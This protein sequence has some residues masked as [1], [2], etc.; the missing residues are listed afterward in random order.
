MSK[1]PMIPSR[2]A[3]WPDLPRLAVTG[4]LALGCLGAAAQTIVE[5]DSAEGAGSASPPAEAVHGGEQ[6]SSDSAWGEGA[7]SLLALQ[8]SGQAASAVAR[9]VPGEV[10]RRARERYLKSFEHAIPER[11]Q[12]SVTHK[13]SGQ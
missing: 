8:R 11:F 4:A 12:S 6:A 9:P 5:R 3:A 10:S 2:L 1:T 13:S 7:R